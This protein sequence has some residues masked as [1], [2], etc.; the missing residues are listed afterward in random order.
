MITPTLEEARELAKGHSVVPIA[1]ELYAD[2]NTSIGVLQSL[3]AAGPYCFLLE[4]VATGEAWGRYSFLGCQPA[5]VLRCHAGRVYQQ[6]G[7]AETALEA[8]PIEAIRG[9]LQRYKSPRIA[10]LPPFTGGLVGYFA[11]EFAAQFEKNLRL[12]AQNPEGFD[13]YRLMLVDRV[14]A[15]DHFRQKI[16]LMVNLPCENLENAY[17]EG[18]AALKDMERLVLRHLPAGEESGAL[19]GP[20][21]P[22]FSKEEFANTVK[23]MQT[24]IKEGDIFQAVPS[25]RFTAPYEGS[26]FSAYRALR[27]VNPSPYMVYMN[28]GDEE[29]A[30]A[31]PE[32]LVALK[33]GELHSYPLAGTCK[34]GAAPAEDAA[35]EAA[36]LQDEKELAEHDMLVDLGRNDLGKVSKF[37][38]VKVEQYRQI[39]RFSHVSHISSRVQGKLAKGRDALDAVG[40]V[41][42]AGTLSGAPKKRAMELIDKAEGQRRGV[43]GGGIGYLDFTG[44]LE[45]CIGIRMALLKNGRVHVQSGA[46][47]VAQSQPAKEYEEVCRKAAAMMEALRGQGGQTAARLGGFGAE[48]TAI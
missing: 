11:Y 38:S 19:T 22:S 29:I 8:D 20:F 24:H 45:L 3:Q 32:T 36:L 26:L 4:S 15:F 1:M 47:I 25:C 43:Y 35:L 39:K 10:K 33:E 12:S 28:L 17:M 16:V 46:G 2:Q 42:P 13:D 48:E 27:T 14:I 7:G 31:S 18:V 6:S 9:L 44:N 37:G 40:A 30:C 5:L 34:R 23:Q 21:S 41:L